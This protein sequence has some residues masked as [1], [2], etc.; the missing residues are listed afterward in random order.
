MPTM[1]TNFKRE[2]CAPC[3]HGHV[4]PNPESARMCDAAWRYARRKELGIDEL[5]EGLR[6]IVFREEERLVIG[7][8]PECYAINAHEPECSRKA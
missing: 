5:I 4:H 1:T 6:K 7:Q 8:C 3:S 2:G